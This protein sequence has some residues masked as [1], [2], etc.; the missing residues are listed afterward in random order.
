MYEREFESGKPGW[1]NPQGRGKT[2][3]TE[4][5]P[6]AATPVAPD[7]KIDKAIDDHQD[8]GSRLQAQSYMVRLLVSRYSVSASVA[9]IIAA[10]PGMGGG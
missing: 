7:R 8:T 2:L 5:H 6:Q 4:E 10:E 9:A 3:Q 1:G